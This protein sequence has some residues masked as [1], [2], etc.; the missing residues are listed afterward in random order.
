MGAVFKRL[1][2]DFFNEIKSQETT[3]HSNNSHKTKNQVLG[4][5]TK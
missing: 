2:E 1:I 4:D 3:Q 5:K